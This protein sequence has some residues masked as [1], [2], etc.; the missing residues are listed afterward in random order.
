MNQLAE[1]LQRLSALQ[2]QLEALRPIAPEQEARILQKLRLDWNFHSNHLEGNRLSYGETKALLLFG[3]TAQGKP[4]KDHIEIEG[5][6]EAI[7][8]IEE[9]VLQERPLTEVFIRG[10]HEQIL[11]RPYQNQALTPDGQP[12]KRWIAVG[13]YKKMPNHVRTV[14]GEMFYFASPEETPIKMQEL[15]D[16][17]RAEEAK[18][19]PQHPLI[20]AAEFHYRFVRIHPFDDGN[21]R[22]A[23]L[24]F[25][26]ILMRGKYPPAVIRSED[27]ARYLETL[28]LA[29]T[30]D[31]E[32]FYRFMAGCA[33]ASLEL[34]LRGAQGLSIEEP[35]DLDKKLRILEERLKG[36][37]A[38][39]LS[40]RSE[41]SIT[42]WLA[43]NFQLIWDCTQ[44][45]IGRF[46]RLYNRCELKI[47]EQGDG[48]LGLRKIVQVLAEKSQDPE[49]LASL[50]S[51]NGYELVLSCNFEG[52][53]LAA[54][55]QKI[56]LLFTEKAVMFSVENQVCLSS[57]YW[58]E[59]NPT[60]LAPLF[61]TMNEAHLA[62]I[63]EKLS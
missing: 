45:E 52:G 35:D 40:M 9:V 8:A 56:K 7:L 12:T 23:R 36:R 32:P 34:V 38:E 22:M 33:Q 51:Q 17:Y 2:A 48:N 39:S 6:N 37:E 60:D 47:E 53:N 30:G 42:N 63:E 29:D 58:L 54:Y 15:V 14:T 21:G 43:H 28:Q 5:H 18:D 1:M 41:G 20:L 55:Q 27:K 3:L 13:E 62:W 44:Q 16:W 31:A 25:N 57:S 26:L 46:K 24:L 11:K 61:K 10:L 59:F 49:L 19:R 4:L 50:V